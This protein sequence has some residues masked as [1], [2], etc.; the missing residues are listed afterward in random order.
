[1]VTSFSY[2]GA[3]GLLA[4]LMG[5]F[6]RNLKY[7]L[8]LIFTFGFSYLLFDSRFGSNMRSV[9]L[10][11]V[12]AIVLMVLTIL[13]K[14]IGQIAISIVTALAFG[15]MLA[16]TLGLT[17]GDFYFWLALIGP[18]VAVGV[19]AFV[20][21]DIGIQIG[22]ALCGGML[23]SEF[24]IYVIA[25]INKLLGGMRGHWL[26]IIKEI[27]SGALFS[28]LTRTNAK[29]TFI[30]AGISA[31]LGLLIQLAINYKKKPKKDRE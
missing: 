20:T 24:V 12:I 21:D 26:S 6:G 1:M 9:I 14:R 10:A 19:I 11:S 22:T 28:H 3:A 25:N 18:A 17:F 2:I 7:P 5:F 8:T 23:L 29:L 30:I 31:A 4:F 16:D 15:Y 13:F 27:T